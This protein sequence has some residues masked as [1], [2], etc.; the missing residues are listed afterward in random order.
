MNGN[1]LIEALNALGVATGV[2]HDIP[3]SLG[4]SYCI[5]KAQDMINVSSYLVGR[6]KAPNHTYNSGDTIVGLPYTS[7]RKW[8]TFVPNNV[9]FETYLTSL[10]DPNSY[11]Y[12][13]DP[14][15]GNYGCL[16]YGSVCGTFVAYC[17]GIKALRHTN[18]DFF[19]IPGMEKIEN[20]SAQGM[21]LGYV[22]NAAKNNRTHAQICIGIERNDGVVTSITLAES[23]DPVCRAVEYTAEEFNNLLVDYTILSYSKIDENT[24]E[25]IIVPYYNK[26]IMP[27]KGNKANWYTTENVIIN[28]LNKADYTNYIVYKDGA[29]Y[30]TAAIGN[31]STINLGNMPYGKYYMVLTNNNNQT[32][33]VEWIVVD[34]QM[35]VTAMNGGVL[36]FTFSSANATPIACCWARPSDYM[37]NLV[38]DITNTDIQKG[39]KD[40]SLSSTHYSCY[41]V[42]GYEGKGSQYELYH[43]YYTTGGNKIRPRMYFKTE[44]GVITTDWNASG[45]ITY[46]E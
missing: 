1:A 14:G 43:G 33:P 16:Y 9:S 7:T 41:G 26:N 5:R 42:E 44:F 15:H 2:T 38:Y 6:I 12:T 22:I 8:C 39:F 4:V 31:G 45:N 11:A 3:S 46:V 35:S 13:V 24:Y 23:T 21:Q 18:W 20:Q 27:A 17:L 30:A 19:G 29:Q 28:V 34:I 10:S 40:T 36:R 25:P 37:A 32:T